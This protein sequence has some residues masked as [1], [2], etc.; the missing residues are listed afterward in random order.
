MKYLYYYL[1]FG[2]ILNIILA[3]WWVLHSDIFFHVD[4]A[5]DFLILHD[6]VSNHNLTLIGPRSGGIL[7]IFHGPAWFYLNLPAFIL[8]KGDPVIVG[9]FWVLLFMVSL[10]I[11]YYV[12]RKLYTHSV[13]MIATFLLALTQASY[14]RTLF[15][16]FGAVMLAPLFFYFLILYVKNKNI[17]Q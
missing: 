7:G 16:P 4:I 13:A 1:G 8:G 15:N 14:V 11:I 5:R 12:T 17:W 9:W 3:S 10:L 6:I 2:I